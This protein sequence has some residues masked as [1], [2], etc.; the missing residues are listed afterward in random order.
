M[1]L[2]NLKEHFAVFLFYL[3]ILALTNAS[4]VCDSYHTRRLALCLRVGLQ[5]AS[6]RSLRVIGWY[7]YQQ[8]METTSFLFLYS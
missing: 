4:T 1:Q 5:I 3:H 2:I 7:I 8:V 6:K